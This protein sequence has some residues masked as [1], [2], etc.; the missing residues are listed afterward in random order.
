MDTIANV[1][2]YEEQMQF[3]IAHLEQCLAEAEDL[4]GRARALLDTHK[5]GAVIELIDEERLGRDV[6]SF[7]ARNPSILKGVS[8]MCLR[9]AVEFVRTSAENLA[10][11]P[12]SVRR[13]PEE[14]K[15]SK[16]ALQDVL[17]SAR[18]LV[19]QMQTS[20]EDLRE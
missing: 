11:G 3:A 9:R 15:A 10:A 8:Q 7:F 16:K 2:I 13:S 19:R 5:R 12:Q 20:C 1:E 6:N 17:D 14:A 18:A 4:R